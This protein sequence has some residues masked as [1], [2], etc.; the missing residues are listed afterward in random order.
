MGEEK[1]SVVVPVFNG[2]RFLAEA[3]ANIMACGMG[4]MH[5][6]IVDDGSTDGTPDVIGGLRGNVSSVRQANRGPAAA[7]NRGIERADGELIAFLDADDLWGVDHPAAA[8]RRF[9]E[10][11][12]LDL[13]IGRTQCLRYEDEVDGH[14]CYRSWRA[15][16]HSANV[17]S[18]LCRRTLFD[19]VG[20][21]DERLKYGEDLDWFLRAREAGARME[22]IDEV[23]L[24]YRVRPGGMLAVRGA[25][26]SGMLGALRRSINRRRVGHPMP[27]DGGALPPILPCGGEG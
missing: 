17:G 24:M 16:F 19:R 25:G 3:F 10:G 18:W 6:V 5:V 21:F 26:R 1:V 11:G 23:C 13:V 15:P 14:S 4:E 2:E 7:R 9:R 8:L 20:L 27:G 22:R 12:D